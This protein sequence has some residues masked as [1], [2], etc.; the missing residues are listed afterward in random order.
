MPRNLFLRQALQS[1]PF[2]PGRAAQSGEG[3]GHV[4]T[5]RGGGG[6]GGG[7]SGG[8]L[9]GRVVE[10]GRPAGKGSGGGSVRNMDAEF[11]E[12]PHFK[13]LRLR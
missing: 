4:T 9:F 7:R 8:H 12:V 11:K 6:R 5:G 10:T 2:A 1:V 13:K 3:G